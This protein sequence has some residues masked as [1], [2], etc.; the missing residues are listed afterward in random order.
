MVFCSVFGYQMLKFPLLYSFANFLANVRFGGLTK[1]DQEDKLAAHKKFYWLL[2]IPAVAIYN[3]NCKT[4]QLIP[5][6]GKILP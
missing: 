1:I 4:W 2:D 3:D 6:N 5:Y